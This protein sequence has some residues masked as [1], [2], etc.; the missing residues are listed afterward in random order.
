MTIQAVDNQSYQFSEDDT[1]I[2]DIDY[3]IYSKTFLLNKT[4]DTHM[5]MVA[6]IVIGCLS[7]CILC[8]HYSLCDREYR[9]ITHAYLIGCFECE[10]FHWPGDK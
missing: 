1:Y 3:A 7:S 5:P 6:V 4:I 2:F 10:F 8:D 9:L